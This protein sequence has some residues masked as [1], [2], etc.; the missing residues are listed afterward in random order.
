MTTD[1][2]T[3]ATKQLEDR[4]ATTA[5]RSEEERIEAYTMTMRNSPPP[6]MTKRVLDAAW[7]AIRDRLR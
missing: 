3:D 5:D 7:R 2:D 1:E 4:P 6:G